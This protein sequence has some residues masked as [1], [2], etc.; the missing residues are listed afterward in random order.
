MIGCGDDMIDT[1]VTI[2]TYPVG[3]FQLWHIVLALGVGS[4]W[5][6]YEKVE[7]DELYTEY[8]R[9]KKRK[10]WLELIRTDKKGDE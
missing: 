1:F 8:L 5:I 4:I 3:A 10:D 6:W 7:S 9:E 2:L